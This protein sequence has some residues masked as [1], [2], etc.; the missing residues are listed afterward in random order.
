M[1]VL[2]SGHGQ[3][4]HWMS[5][6]RHP[7]RGPCTALASVRLVL[8][9]RMSHIHVFVVKQEMSY[10]NYLKVCLCKQ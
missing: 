3:P 9:L 2:P 4:P 6:V 7:V 5:T 8:F 10:I 1:N